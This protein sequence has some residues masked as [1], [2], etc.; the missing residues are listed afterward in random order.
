MNKWRLLIWGYIY[1]TD[2]VCPV[3]P[4][5]TSAN[6][7][8]RHCHTLSSG[9]GKEECSDKWNYTNFGLA[10]VSTVTVARRTAIKCWKNQEVSLYSSPNNDIAHIAVHLKCNDR[11]SNCVLLYW[12]W[13]LNC[14]GQLEEVHKCNASS[15]TV[16]TEMVL[17]WHCLLNNV[18]CS[19][20][21][22]CC[23]VFRHK[24][25]D[26]ERSVNATIKVSVYT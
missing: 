20:A 8:Y 26:T 12:L 6:S 1:Y 18:L 21:I 2:W 5:C 10:T 19:T 13:K 11:F 3:T 9:N 15:Y 22:D 14:S 4:Y 7:T 25:L 23:S 16:C 24:L 17:K